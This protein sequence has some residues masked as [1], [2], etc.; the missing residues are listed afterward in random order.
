MM[1]LTKKESESRMEKYHS[2]STETKKDKSQKTSYDKGFTPKY[3]TEKTP[4]EKFNWKLV[5]WTFIGGCGAIILLA[6]FLN[7]TQ[8]DNSAQHQ[9]AV[10][11][12]KIQ[13]SQTKIAEKQAQQN[14]NPNQVQS[15]NQDEKDS[16]D[17]Y[18]DDEQ[19]QANP[20]PNHQT[21]QT[22]A[23]QN[24]QAIYQRAQQTQQPTTQGAGYYGDLNSAQQAG[25]QAVDSG[26]ASNYKVVNN[27]KGYTLILEH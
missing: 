14:T 1:R 5:F 25:I 4:K 3:D 27:G 10:R 8:P 13:K 21:A 9:R 7:T 23:Q 15:N 12:E 19:Q 22:T 17:Y 11:N 6:T 16:N 20:Y 26:A 24:Q 2:D 18:S